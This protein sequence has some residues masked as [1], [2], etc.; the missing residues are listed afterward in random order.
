MQNVKNVKIFKAK[1]KRQLNRSHIM[2]NLANQYTH[3]P[4]KTIAAVVKNIFEI[5]T[6]TLANGNKIELRGFGSFSIRYRLTRTAR[7]PKT[8]QKINLPSQR[9]V[10]FKPGKELNA[11]I[12]KIKPINNS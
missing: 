11:R 9:V 6:Y 4:T 10:H 5:M 3:L 1:T 7:N 8:G 12:N 2:Q